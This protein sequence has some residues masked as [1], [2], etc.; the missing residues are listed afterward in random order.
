MNSLPVLSNEEISKMCSKMPSFGGCILDKELNSVVLK[1]GLGDKCWFILYLPL[2]QEG[3][4]PKET[5]SVIGHWVL[6]WS[7]RK[8]KPVF[9]DPF[10]MPPSKNILKLIIRL[11]HVREFPTEDDCSTQSR[12]GIRQQFECNQ[13]ELQDIEA[14]SCGWWCLAMYSMGRDLSDFT[15]RFTA[16][17]AKGNE[18][19]L[20]K[21]FS[22]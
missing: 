9:F 12:Q 6:L 5:P 19:L 1:Q 11:N 3:Q 10:G 4:V 21:I 8:R 22:S 15:E 20:T 2:E 13:V 7:A 14:S 18:E 17:A 16:F